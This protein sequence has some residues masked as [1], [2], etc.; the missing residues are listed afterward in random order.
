V[1]DAANASMSGVTMPSAL[2]R[3]IAGAWAEILLRTW[4]GI[5]QSPF[6]LDATALLC[7]NAVGEIDT[8]PPGGTDG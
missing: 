4:N 1:S 8:G 3:A 7:H 2:I 5:L 6:P